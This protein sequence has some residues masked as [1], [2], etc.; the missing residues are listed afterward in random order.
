[1]ESRENQFT[2]IINISN[3]EFILIMSIVTNKLKIVIK[4]EESIEYFDREFSFKELNEFKAFLSFDSLEEIFTSLNENLN[5]TEK[6]SLEYNSDKDLDLKFEFS[7][8]TKKIP[9]Q[10][11]IEK[12]QRDTN[13]LIEYILEDLKKIK[14]ESK[15][16]RNEN[17]EL[18]NEIKI[19]KLKSKIFYLNQGERNYILILIK[20]LLL[21]YIKFYF[22][23][24]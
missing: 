1:M 14:R 11:T 18:R 10:F 6:I 21:I 3:D 24:L 9:V 13:F 12:K 4:N 16:L 7:I 20:L 5:S 17:K 22:Q 2:K 23:V 15:E 19:I 8:I